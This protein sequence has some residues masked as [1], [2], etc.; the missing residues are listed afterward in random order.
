MSSNVAPLTPGSADAQR[1]WGIVVALAILE[2][3]FGSSRAMWEVR[4]RAFAR[5]VFVLLLHV[6][7]RVVCAT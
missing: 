6:I 4:Q 5:W 2:K 7:T 1:L 3:R